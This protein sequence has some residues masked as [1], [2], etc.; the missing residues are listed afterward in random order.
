[1][2]KLTDAQRDIL[3]NLARD[4]KTENADSAALHA[5]LVRIDELE[6]APPKSTAWRD[7]W[8]TGFK[9]ATPVPAAT[10]AVRFDGQSFFLGDSTVPLTG[11][12]AAFARED[13]IRA[14]LIE[15]RNPHE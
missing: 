12:A 6:L 13:A 9:P 11:A 14:G 2:P 4:A 1:M 15:P 10:P 8:G 7:A 3:E 5:A